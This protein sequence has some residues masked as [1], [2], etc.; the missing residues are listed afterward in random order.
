MI[1][2]AVFG[3]E[4]YFSALQVVVDNR[5]RYTVAAVSWDNVHRGSVGKT[6]ERMKL[7]TILSKINAFI[8]A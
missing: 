2:A 4:C 5:Y 1:G 6:E 7:L 3:G 8:S